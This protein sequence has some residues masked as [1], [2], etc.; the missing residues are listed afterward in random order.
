[1]SGPKQSFHPSPSKPKLR[2]PKGA[3][4]AHVHVFRPSS[5]FPY[6]KDAPFVPADA[7]KEK[8]FAMHAVLGIEHCV[9][10]QSTCHGFD[11]S[12]VAD[13]IKAKQGA[14][15]GV[16]LAPASVDNE[17]LKRL[18]G[19]GFRGV[20]FNFMKHLGAGA[21]IEDVIELSKRLAPLEMHLQVHFES[22]MIHDLAP[23]F[24]K[25][26]V[27]VVIDHMGRVDASRGIDQPDFRA[28]LELMKDQRIL[29]KVSGA[30]RCTKQAPPYKD[31]IPFAAKLVDE[32]G[33][34]TLWGTD[35]PHPN[36]NHVPDDGLL[37]DLLSEIA[38]SEAQRQALLADNPRRFYRFPLALC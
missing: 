34:R 24:R 29:V 3:C 38:P 31:A 22:S 4:D 11:N 6:A 17:E 16:A 18:D 1:M 9:I 14:Y 35:W 10:V 36:M 2:L 7:P 8:L 33:D 26:A 12:V 37:A 30:E 27:P 28:L 13:A 23:W 19:F 20:R 5:V 15:C 21:K 32:F 25:S